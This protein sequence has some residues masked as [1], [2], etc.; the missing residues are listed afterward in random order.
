MKTI[1]LSENRYRSLLAAEEFCRAA[2]LE[3][4]GPQGLVTARSW[5]WF[6]RWMRLAGK[7]KYDAPKPTRAVWCGNCLCRHV[8]GRHCKVV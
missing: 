1:Q 6:D 2:R 3:Y 5:P 4:A 7:S 8:V